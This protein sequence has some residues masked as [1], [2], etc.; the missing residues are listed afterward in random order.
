MP[1]YGP[2]PRTTE[3]VPKHVPVQPEVV[4]SRRSCP[5]AAKE[6]G[7]YKIK[8]GQDKKKKRKKKDF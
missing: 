3:K 1:S 4:E 5:R 2:I 7:L 8:V 6:P